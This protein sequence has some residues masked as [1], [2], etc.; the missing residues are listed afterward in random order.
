MKIGLGEGWGWGSDVLTIRRVGMHYLEGGKNHTVP[1]KTAAG[2]S[3]RL[4]GGIT[5]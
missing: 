3:G 2:H 4:R 1:K 5:Y